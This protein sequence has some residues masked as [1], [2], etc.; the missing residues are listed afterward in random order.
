MLYPFSLPNQ[1]PQDGDL[2]ADAFMGHI[3]PRSYFRDV[4]SDPLPQPLEDGRIG[5]VD[6]GGEIVEDLGGS[7][8]YHPDQGSVQASGQSSHTLRLGSG[9]NNSP[10]HH[11]FLVG[12]FSLVDEN[13]GSIMIGPT[14]VVLGGNSSARHPTDRSLAI[15]A[16][17]EPPI[18]V[19]HT[20]ARHNE[21]TPQQDFQ[22]VTPEERHSYEMNAVLH[23]PCSRAWDIPRVRS[24]L[25]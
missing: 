9:S 18:S 11:V 21:V 8:D 10:N 13:G 16:P 6:L 14:A 23:G 4:I 17:K 15:L 1:P 3:G 19:D 5:R 24:I 12:T 7:S 25:Y 20:A 22:S 2:L